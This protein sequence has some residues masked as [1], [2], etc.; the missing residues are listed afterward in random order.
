[1]HADDGSKP[2]SPGRRTALSLLA[3][4]GAAVL[5]AGGARGQQP[6]PAC[7]V[8]PEQTEGPYFVDTRLAR[9][10]IRTDP[11]TGQ[12]EGG[13]PLRLEFRVARLD[14]RGCAPW[15]GAQVEL[16]QCN[17]LGLYSGV[18]DAHGDTRGRQFLRG[19]QTTDAHGIA[20]FTTLYPGWYP[21]RTVHV[22]FMIREAAGSPRTAFTSQ[23]YFDDALSD[24][25]FG[26]APYAGR[27]A[28]STR[29]ADDGIYR[30]GGAQLLLAV[31]ERAGALDASFD[32]GLDVRR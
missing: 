2:V 29:N 23:L 15:P 9:S 5:R 32:I 22:H 17:A 14:A 11:A 6:R 12:V 26:L 3:L 4:A 10:D 20:R 30:R 27:G 19:H 25:I 13:M 21:G 18:R 7:V 8:R 24:R 28:R 1:M 16:W 31:A